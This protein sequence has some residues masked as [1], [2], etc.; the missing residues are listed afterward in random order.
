MR[1]SVIEINLKA[2]HAPNILYD[3]IMLLLYIPIGALHTCNKHLEN[4]E[5]QPLATNQ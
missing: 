1:W 3:I 5:L 4:D 2:Q